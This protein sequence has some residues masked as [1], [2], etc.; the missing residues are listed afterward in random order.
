[1]MAKRGRKEKVWR[2]SNTV[3]FAIRRWLNPMPYLRGGTAGGLVVARVVAKKHMR[4]GNCFLMIRDCNNE[5]SLDVDVDTPDERVRTIKK[6]DKLIVSL[7]EFQDAV[8]AVEHIATVET[9]DGGWKG[10]K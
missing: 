10:W 5:I 7:V 6:L 9:A 8:R 2:I 4:W 1:M 3:K